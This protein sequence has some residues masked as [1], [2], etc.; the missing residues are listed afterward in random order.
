[1]L[2]AERLWLLRTP[3]WLEGAMWDWVARGCAMAPLQAAG[4]LTCFA[5][6]WA[7]KATNWNS[8]IKLDR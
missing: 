4:Q 2:P 6:R 3:L 5:S 8:P 1:M 7:V